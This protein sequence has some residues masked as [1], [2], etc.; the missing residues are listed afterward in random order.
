MAGPQGSALV[1]VEGG[2]E[3]ECWM[4]ARFPGADGVISGCYS[5]CCNLAPDMDVTGAS[6]GAGS[7]S[8]FLRR[9]DC[10]RRSWCRGSGR[11]GGLFAREQCEGR[12]RCSPFRNQENGKGTSW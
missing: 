3:T 5:Q 4:N 1:M 9:T 11:V 12:P 6:S 10:K 7:N 2:K 8:V